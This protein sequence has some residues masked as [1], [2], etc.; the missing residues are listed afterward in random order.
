MKNQSFNLLKIK[1]YLKLLVPIIVLI[2]ATIAVMV[3]FGGTIM[4]LLSKPENI[5]N[6]VENYGIFGALIFIAFQVIQIVVAIIPGEPIQI[7]G[8]Y[9]YGTLGGF[10]LSTIGIMMGSIIAFLISRKFGLPVVK[11]FIKEEKL[12]YYKDKFESKKGLLI[13]FLLCLIPGIPKDVLVYAVGLTL[14]R[15]RIFFAIYFFARI[16]AGILA[17]YMG[18]QLGQNNIIGFIV[19]GVIVMIILGTGYIFKERIYQKLKA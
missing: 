17:S 6:F 18:A 2:V 7:A 5:K 16:P 14:I 1:K 10:T 3:P 9:I 12:F 11:I 4:E 8:G 19:T 15:F 13:I